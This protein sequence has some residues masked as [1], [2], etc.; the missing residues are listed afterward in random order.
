MVLFFITIFRTKFFMIALNNR[1]I[2]M[3]SYIYFEVWKLY[4]THAKYTIFFYI[5]LVYS[6]QMVY[7]LV[8]IV[9]SI[10][11]L[12]L[13]YQCLFHCMT[14]MLMDCIM[15]SSNGNIFHV[16]GLLVVVVVV[17]GG[18]GESPVIPPQMPVT[19]YFYVF[20]DLRL[21]KRL[22]KQSRRWWLDTPSRS[23]WRHWN[24]NKTHLA[25][26]KAS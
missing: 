13:M 12:I 17:E 23:L 8:D 3:V 22:S 14:H 1:N 21:N 9:N 11:V 2:W 25:L 15:T 26:F 4:F 5:V 10:W 6:Q 18:G 20:F 19:R 24:G 7:T 16:I